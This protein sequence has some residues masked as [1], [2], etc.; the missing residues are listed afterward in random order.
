M[1]AK[2]CI[3][4]SPEKTIYWEWHKIKGVA[5]TY[6]RATG[7][8]SFSMLLKL[9]QRRQSA[10]LGRWLTVCLRYVP[11]VWHTAHAC[12][13]C[14]CTNF[15]KRTIFANPSQTLFAKINFRRFWGSD[16]RTCTCTP[17][18]FG[19]LKLS[20]QPCMA[21]YYACQAAPTRPFLLLDMWEVC[22]S[23]R[24]VLISVSK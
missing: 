9:E 17:V 8:L 7:G 2:P 18:S 21:C 4:Q 11:Y 20:G 16:E 5:C 10:C 12:A 1:Q 23:M 15:R 3:V 6:N 19:S 13:F 14:K 24:C 22:L